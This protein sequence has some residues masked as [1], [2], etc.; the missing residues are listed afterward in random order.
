MLVSRLIGSQLILSV[1]ILQRKILALQNYPDLQCLEAARRQAILSKIAFASL[2]TISNVC[3]H[4]SHLTVLEASSMLFLLMSELL[5]LL[6]VLIHECLP[7]RLCRMFH[8]LVQTQNLNWIWLA[9]IRN[10]NRQSMSLGHEQ[11][12][13]PSK[14]Q[15]AFFTLA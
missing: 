14:S 13:S 5:V 8:L 4:R 6:A 10:S 15:Y 2:P 11:S 9:L 3:C 7:E 12:F 1:T